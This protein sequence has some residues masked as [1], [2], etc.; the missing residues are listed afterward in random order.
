V[1]KLSDALAAYAT[2]LLTGTRLAVA[3]AA[4]IAADPQADVPPEAAAAAAALRAGWAAA[5]LGGDD[6]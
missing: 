4:R 6:R 5:T 2:T 1:T 3:D